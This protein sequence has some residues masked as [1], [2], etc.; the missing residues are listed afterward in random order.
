MAWT[1]GGL[2]RGLLSAGMDAADA[3][4]ENG[5]ATAPG[6]ERGGNAEHA[7]GP[8]S[9]DA[10]ARSA[11]M[12]ASVQGALNSPAG[13]LA[14][15]ALSIA[16]PQFG[17]MAN[18]MS[19][20]QS[21][22]DAKES[23]LS[24]MAAP[25]IGMLGFAKPAQAINSAYSATKSAQKGDYATAAVTGLLGM[26]MLNGVTTGNPFG[27]MAVSRGLLGLASFADSM[28]GDDTGGWGV[29]SRNTNA[30][31][32]F[33]DSLGGPASNGAASNGAD[34]D[35][36]WGASHQRSVNS[37]VGF[38]NSMG[39]PASSNDSSDGGSDGSGDGGDGGGSGDGG[40]G[41]GGSH[42]DGGGW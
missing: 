24:A 8:V 30:A 42:G 5:W 15:A 23:T 3:L 6:Q 25:A 33:N 9:A 14:R 26:G 12:A 4:D 22:P 2:F 40:D 13:R 18:M 38:N 16:A 34:N 28:R 32:G 39:A 41:G 35:G 10:A 20:D 17:V 1:Q 29:T 37:A 11:S 21:R 31:I 36:G 19:V 7:A 27:D